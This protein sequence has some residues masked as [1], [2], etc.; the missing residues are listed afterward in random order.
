M[1][2]LYI[3]ETNIYVI[4]V[5]LLQHWDIPWGVTWWYAA[6]LQYLLRCWRNKTVFLYCPQKHQESKGKRYPCGMCDHQATTKHGNRFMKKLNTIVSSMISKHQ[7][8]RLLRGTYNRF[9]K[10]LSIFAGS[11]STLLRLILDCICMKK[12]SPT[13]TKI[14]LQKMS[15]SFSIIK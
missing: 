8:N 6:F 3:A 12:S 9:I 13:T 5:T 4:S 7:L 2:F 11:V 1:P 10:E 15:T 14:P